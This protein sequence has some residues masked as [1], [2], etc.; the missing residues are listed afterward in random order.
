MVFDSA[1]FCLGL[2]AGLVVGAAVM[3]VA[4]L[5]AYMSTRP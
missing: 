4:M 5:C 1:S 2:V 3:S